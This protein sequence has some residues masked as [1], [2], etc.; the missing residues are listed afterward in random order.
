[1]GHTNVI[2]LLANE[3]AGTGTRVVV[4]ER[5]DSSEGNQKKGLRWWFIQRVSRHLYSKAGGI[6]AVSQG[7]AESV[8]MRLRIPIERIHVVYNPVV[9]DA[10]LEQ[11]NLEEHYPWWPDNACPMI[12]AAGRLTTQKDFHTLIRAFYVVRKKIDATL[13]IM[14]E[15][16]LRP[17]LERL[18]S[19]HGLQGKV[20]LPGFVR[21]PLFVMKKADLFVLSSAWEG[22]PNVL[23]Q[24][25]ACGVPVVSTSCPSGPVEILEHGKW[26]RLV[27]V[28]DV[29][30]LAQAII[31]TLTERVHPDVSSRASFFCVDDAVNGYLK[32]LF[33]GEK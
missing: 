6:H 17:E 13:V 20:L 19:E 28:G 5:N 12:V 21:N 15:G 27:P 30:F 7:V 8:A 2:A 25:M 23:I 1:M 14:G 24:A 3:L 22:L 29:K 32:L 9:S 4:S 18:I 33:P 26:G 16:E 11:A 10:L 31:D